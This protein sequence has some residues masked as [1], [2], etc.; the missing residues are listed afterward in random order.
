MKLLQL[1]KKLNEEELSLIANRQGKIYTSKLHGIGPIINPMKDDFYYFEDAIVV[2][3]VIVKATAMLLILSKVKYIY[4]YVLSEKAKEIL[5]QYQVDYD[6]EKLV[7]YII[8]RTH[9]GMCPMEQTV[10][11]LTDLNEA[12][13]ALI[14]KQKELMNQ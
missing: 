2:Y 11:N 9:D 6:Y 10:Y 14:Q 8:N 7:P 4:A 13:E 12:Y 1:Q 5:D 3:K